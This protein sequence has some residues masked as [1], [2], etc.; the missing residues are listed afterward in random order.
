MP[1]FQACESFFHHF[2]APLCGT[3]LSSLGP[4]GQYPLTTPF[5]A[6]LCGTGLSSLISRKALIGKNTTLPPDLTIQRPILNRFGQV[7]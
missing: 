5:P 4:L 1:A 6:P 2:P 3:G 7:I